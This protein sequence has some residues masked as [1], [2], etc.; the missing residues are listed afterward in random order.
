MATIKGTVISINSQVI[1]V[2]FAD[3]LPKIGSL[4]K[5]RTNYNVDEF[6]EAAQAISKNV[7]RAYAISKMD[8]IAIGNNVSTENKGIEVPV[9]RKVLGRIINLMGGAYDSATNP[10]VTDERA[11]IMVASQTEKEAFDNIVSTEVLETGVKIIDLLLPIPKGGK[12]GLLGGAG[13]GK[14]VVVQEL[15]NSFIQNHGGL[16]VFTGIGERTREGHELWKEAQ[17]LKFLDNTAFVFAQMNEVPGARFRAAYSGIK[18]AEHFRDVEKKDVLLFVDNIFR[19]VQAGAEISSL[20]ERLPSAVGYQPTL[21]YEMGA[22]QER[23]GSTKDGA[24]T[25]IQAVYIPADDLTDPSA[26]ASFAHFDST[27]ILDRDIAAQGRFPAVNPLESNSNLLARGYVSDAHYDTAQKVL[28]I[29]ES[30]NQLQDIIMI[31]GLNG[32]TEA[33][34][35]T[36]ASARRIQNFL[37]QPFSVAEKFS[38]VPGKTVSIS[39]TIS[40]FSK[41]ISGSLNHIPEKMFLYKGSISEVIEA[42]EKKVK[43]DLENKKEDKV[44]EA[45]SAAKSNKKVKKSQDKEISKKHKMEKQV[46]EKLT[47]TKAGLEKTTIMDFKE[48]KQD[49]K[50]DKKL[51]KKAKKAKN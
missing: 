39:E 28:T 44:E 34:K 19:F 27:I 8:G 26:V 31:L 47:K 6:F 16:S 46:R 23:I 13:V 49:S 2:R 40:S 17:E 25:S 9:G 32:L 22:F 48:I 37:T 45:I 41:I 50:Q 30:F 51:L 33:D 3:K 4:L 20:L 14:T 43:Q 36:V 29:L 18:I 10:I 5:V 24:I 42:Y 35:Q 12:V 11:E 21:T 15:I 7:I 1:D 38:G